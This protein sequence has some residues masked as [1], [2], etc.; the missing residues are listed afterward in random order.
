MR[1]FFY[2]LLMLGVL[3]SVA[4]AQTQGSVLDRMR[5]LTC[6]GND[7][8]K[9]D[10]CEKTRMCCEGRVKFQGQFPRPVTTTWG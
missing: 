10:C 1:L 6:P 5:C 7:A 3:L 8:D 9:K 2:C 4:R